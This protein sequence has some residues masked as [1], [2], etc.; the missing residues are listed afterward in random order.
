MSEVTISINGRSYDIGC[1]H[2]QEGRI[3]DLASYID[4]RVEQIARSGAAY[5]DSHLM[6][7][8]ALVLA[9]ELFEA[10]EAAAH[11]PRGA[12]AGAVAPAQKEDDLAIVR[13]IEQ[14]TQRIDGISSRVQQAS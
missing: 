2:G 4:Q 1:D 10:K 3:V 6:I 7:L 5:N 9:D 13:L 12:R 14:I 11:A 8:T